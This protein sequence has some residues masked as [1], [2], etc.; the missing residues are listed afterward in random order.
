MELRHLRYFVET[1]RELH[2]ARAA[3]K[4]NVTQPALSRQILALEKELGVE[5]FS[6]S[7]KWKIELTQAGKL[8]F[9]EAQK[10][11]KESHRAINLARSA[12]DGGC[13]RLAIGAISSTIESQAF[14]LAMKEMRRRFPQLV[15]E[16]VEANSGGLP[17]RV[18]QR[19]LD[20]AFLRSI[21]ALPAD[22]SLN[23]EHL[24]NDKLVIAV[25]ADHPLA[26]EDPLPAKRLAEE[27]F[28]LVP[29]RTS[30]LLRQYV[31]E[32]FSKHG[33]FSPHI[34]L[35]IYNTY[36]ALSMV[37]SGLGIS[38]VSESYTGF[39]PGKVVYRHLTDCAPELPL[40][41]ITPSE[42]CS[43]SADIF[44]EILKQQRKEQGI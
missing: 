32:F 38:V 34:D 23:C 12:G 30:S 13:G 10:I 26:T 15:L 17:D 22:P 6:R 5:L 2:F 8:F 42:N 7:N 9:S 33:R 37:A 21:P 3:E 27:S 40:F 29:V 31:E 4:L 11:L 18:R 1:A 14:S 35:E 36:T 20:I 41:V 25:P 44:L 19:E 39:F 28:I 43:R 16:V 24:W